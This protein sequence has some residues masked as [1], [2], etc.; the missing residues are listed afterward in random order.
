MYNKIQILEKEIIDLNNKLLMK[1]KDI[2]I[3]K[4]IHE[5]EIQLKDIE[6]LKYKIKNLENLSNN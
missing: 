2:E 5:N 1:D 4:K 3:I 6:L